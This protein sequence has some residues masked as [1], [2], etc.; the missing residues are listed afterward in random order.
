MARRHLR[1]ERPDHTL[2]PSALVHEA[3][4]KLVDQR[5]AR[6]EDRQHFFAIAA[7]IMRRILVDY[8][9]RR[10]YAKRGGGAPKITLD[11]ALAATPLREPEL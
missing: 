3:Y 9:R 10:R 8:E 11:D 4:L 7:T 2:Q 5:Q 1:R 6:F